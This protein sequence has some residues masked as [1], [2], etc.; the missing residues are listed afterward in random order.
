M[1]FDII[2]LFPKS[3]DS[4][5]AESIL[6]RASERGI[7]EINFVDLRDFS[8]A[9]IARGGRGEVYAK[10][11]DRPYGGGPG[12]VVQL[13]PIYRA[14]ES[15]RSRSPASRGK[16]KVILLSPGGVK[17]DGKRARRLARSEHLILIAGRYEGV[18][19]R[20]AR[21]V[22][23]FE[24]SIG[25][26][27]LAGG[28]LPALVT[29]EAV[30][31]FLPGVLGTHESLEEV[32]GS[33]PVYTRPEVFEPTPGV[34]WRVPKVLTGGDHGKIEE[35]RRKHGQGGGQAATVRK[36]KE[37]PRPKKR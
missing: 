11:D 32:K 9:A 7:I 5:L 24:L 3:G 30:S 26:Y 4:Y 22:A 10:V 27:V 21:K 8:D 6:K 36:V 18:D 28:E 31:R 35:W 17:L 19:H 25:D 16:T 20:V 14:V 1:R 12:M 23:D 13:P 2:T 33:Y 29:I 37:R 15:L 34:R